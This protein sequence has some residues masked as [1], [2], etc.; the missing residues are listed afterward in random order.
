VN[1]KRGVRRGTGHDSM[2]ADDEVTES[3]PLGGYFSIEGDPP[4][5]RKR[6]ERPAKVSR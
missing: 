1:K 6:P 2:V 5:T 3:V 4:A